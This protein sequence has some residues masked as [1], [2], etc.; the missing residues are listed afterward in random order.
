MMKNFLIAGLVML[1]ASATQASYLYW[2]VNAGVLK[3]AISAYNS[4]WSAG[5]K[6]E[7]IS[8]ARLVQVANNSGTSVKS[9]VGAV[10][11]SDFGTMQGTAIDVSTLGS[12]N[13]SYYI[14]IISTAA[15]SATIPYQEIAV[16][17]TKSYNDLVTANAVYT[18]SEMAVPSLV[19]WT[20]GTYAAAP[21]PTS[22]L[23]LIFGIG[24]L[25]LKRKR[26]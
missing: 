20:G 23:L 9:V 1:A 19:A 24:L 21:E 26:V 17:E 10:A 11:A 7:N 22:G 4:K 18:G 16:S 8:G 3:D 13:Y 2:Q 12:A 5:V 15:T 25:G 14:E 6:D